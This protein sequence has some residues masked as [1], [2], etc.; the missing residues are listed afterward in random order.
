MISE[1]YCKPPRNIK[2]TSSFKNCREEGKS[3][4]NNESNDIIIRG[5]ASSL[6]LAIYNENIK[7]KNLS[8]YVKLLL[9][10][11]FLPL[12]GYCFSVIHPQWFFIE[13]GED[14]FWVNLLMIYDEQ[15][16]KSF[17]IEI[18]MTEQCWRYLQK[19]PEM[20]CSFFMIFKVTGALAFFFII[21]GST[22]Q[23]LHIC[24]LIAILLKKYQFLQWWF[25]IKLKTLQVSFFVL[26]I[27]GIGIWM[28]FVIISQ[29][30]LEKFGIA[31]YLAMGSSLIDTGVFCYFVR[32]KKALK[33]RKLIN[34]LLNPDDII[35][36]QENFN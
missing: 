17:G 7:Y 24:Q 8:N 19:N 32:L 14:R 4:R 1:S 31:F 13:F 16:N 5:R 33:E 29:K 11:N 22:M 18:W 10:L 23:T 20:T 21:V 28:V 27:G 30:T 15:L 26:Y 6:S 36:R 2:S 34:N 9:L 3:D 35:N 12:L 25:C